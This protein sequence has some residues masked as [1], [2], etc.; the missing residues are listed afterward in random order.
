M[1]YN[2]TSQKLTCPVTLQKKRGRVTAA[3]PKLPHTHSVHEQCAPVHLAR[4]QGGLPPSWLGHN[5]S[6]TRALCS[7]WTWGAGL[8]AAEG[9]EAER[10][11]GAWITNA[12]FHLQ[13][14]TM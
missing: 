8:A 11:G 6:S 13:Q 2:P 12:S 5:H 10:L 1:H 7:L 9:Y 3:A 14:Q 4:A